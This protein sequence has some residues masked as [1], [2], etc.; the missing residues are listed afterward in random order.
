AFVEPAVR[1]FHYVD[2]FR[3]MGPC[4]ALLAGRRGVAG[5]GAVAAR[6]VPAR[7]VL[8]G[9]ELLTHVRGPR[10]VTAPVGGGRDQQRRR[11]RRA[12]DGTA[13][14]GTAGDGTARD[15]TARDGTAGGR[16][17]GRGQGGGGHRGGGRRGGGRR[18][19][20]GHGRG[21]GGRA[22][23]P[24]RCRGISVAGWCP[25]G[26]RAFAPRGPAA[27]AA[28]CRRCARPRS[29]RPRH[30]TPVAARPAIPR[31]NRP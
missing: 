13:R 9:P 21:P 31:R 22:G 3:A 23:G 20:R 26:A 4:A 16:A 12:G 6:R 25:G 1:R 30:T 14:D 7:R 11:Q 19:P 24:S 2:L 27:P 29:P 10:P 15:G 17:R 18:G 28:A 8:A 5:L